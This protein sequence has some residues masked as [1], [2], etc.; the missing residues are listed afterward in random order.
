MS[1]A[2]ALADL[3]VC[4]AGATTV[5]ELT[6]TGSPAV[7]IPLASSAE[8]HQL[9]NARILE[10]SGAAAVVKESEI[11]SGRLESVLIE[12]L[13]QPERRE[14][15]AQRAKQLG[16]AEAAAVIVQDLIE[17]ISPS[18]VTGETG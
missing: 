11:E 16:R 9:E 3:I 15:M 13:S 1:S 12:L 4:R 18:D 7:L 10:R 17:R 8:S 14:A 2:Y 6:R 5:A